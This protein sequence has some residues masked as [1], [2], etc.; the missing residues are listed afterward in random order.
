MGASISVGFDVTTNTYLGGASCPTT[1]ALTS[2]Y[3]A[4]NGAGF[5]SS[6]TWASKA[7]WM[8]RRDPCDADATWYGI[9]CELQTVASGG[10]GVTKGVVALDFNGNT[11][12]GQLPTQLGQ[13]SVRSKGA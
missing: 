2:L 10:D 7:N 1:K 3:K 6:T 4:A 9:T 8:V 11:V 5:P 13:V 12:S